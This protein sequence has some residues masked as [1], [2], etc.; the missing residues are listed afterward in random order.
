MTT[1]IWHILH[2]NW[3]FSSKCMLSSFMTTYIWII[4]Y[5][6]YRQKVRCHL[7]WQRTFVSLFV[8]IVKMYVVIFNDNVHSYHYLFLSSKCTLQSLMTT[9]ICIIICF[10]SLKCT[11][12][13]LMTTYICIIIC[14]Y[15]QNV[16]CHL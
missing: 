5:I 13:S 10:L 4:N 6:Y 15:Y 14:F 1:Y 9:Y 2:V 12:Q 8:F 11:L 7:S 3:T 16:R